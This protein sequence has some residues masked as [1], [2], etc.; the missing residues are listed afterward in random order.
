MKW[1]N[2]YN[3]IFAI[4]RID[5]KLKKNNLKVVGTGFVINT[6]PIYILTCNHVVSEGT[7]NNDG[8]IVYSV[9]KRSDS[10]KEFDL[11]EGR[12]SY[13]KAKKIFYNAECDIAILEI[14]PYLNKEVAQQLNIFNT[15][16]LKINFQEK[17]RKIGLPIEW[18]SAGVLGELTLTPRF[19]KGNIVTK[20]IT[21]Y[22]YKFINANGEEQ[23]QTIK[24][25]NFLEIDQLFFPGCSGAP[26]ISST[27]KGEVIGYV[28]GFKSWPIIT[29][30]IL[31]QKVEILD[32]SKPHS[33]KVKSKVP[34]VASLS[35]AIDVKT[36]K[37]FLIKNGFIKKSIIN[38]ILDICFQ[39]NLLKNIKGFTKRNLVRKF[40]T[41]KL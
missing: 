36:V 21:N 30:N 39:K 41:K 16:P 8:S 2:L 32:N 5:T 34:L 13:L 35:L 40:L 24:D 31:S 12:L 28:H 4:A 11:R 7:E 37:D 1:T 9:I 33:V 27:K 26:V 23:S 3:S 22:N 14:D 6:D 19:F 38:K 17:I 25:A 29:D 10:F 20:Y 15:R 18:I